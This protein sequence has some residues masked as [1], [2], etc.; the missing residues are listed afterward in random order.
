MDGQCR[1]VVPHPA[2]PCPTWAS[3]ATWSCVLPMRKMPSPSPPPHARG[4]CTHA[5]VP[6]ALAPCTHPSNKHWRMAPLIAGPLAASPARLPACR[7]QQ[8]HLLAVFD[9]H[10]G[11]AAANFAADSLVPVVEEQ[12]VLRAGQRQAGAGPSSLAA[13]L[14]E[15]VIHS[16]LELQ[17]RFA[18]TGSVGGCAATVVLQVGRGQGPRPGR[19][20]RAARP[21]ALHKPSRAASRGG[22][23]SASCPALSCVGP[24]DSH[25][26]S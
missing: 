12:L 18:Y 16:F 4:L 9:G 15:V 10:N 23:W 17:R 5:L 11:D 1:P 13:Q 7:P 20:R 26:T 24:S 21:G 2:L 22:C 25:L 8:Y 6:R 19:R 14:Q 3:C